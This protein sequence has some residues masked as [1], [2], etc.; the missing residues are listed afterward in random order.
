[1]R[2]TTSSTSRTPTVLRR[3]A[4]GRSRT[5]AADSSITSMALSGRK[6]SFRW[7][8]DR[9]TAAWSDGAVKR[10]PWCSS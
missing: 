6:R 3:F 8:T 4:P 2:A 5:A 10:T 7:R 9:S 1:M